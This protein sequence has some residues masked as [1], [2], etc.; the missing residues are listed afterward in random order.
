MKH[1]LVGMPRRNADADCF[2][3]LDLTHLDGSVGPTEISENLW[4]VSWG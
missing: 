2:D 4:A 3:V 1:D